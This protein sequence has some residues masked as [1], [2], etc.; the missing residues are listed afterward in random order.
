MISL[1]GVNGRSVINSKVKTIARELSQRAVTIMKKPQFLTRWFDKPIDQLKEPWYR[2]GRV[3]SIIDGVVNVK[4]GTTWLDVGC[5]IGQFLHVVNVNYSISGSGIDDFDD[6]NVIEICRKYFQ[7]EIEHPKDL[8]A[9]YS[10]KY[11]PRRIDQI[12]FALNER[13]SFI[14][15]LEVLEHMINTDAF[16]DECNEHLETRGYLVISTPNINSL[17]NRFTGWWGVYPTGLEY[18]TVVH[19]V[20]LYNAK[21]L[22]QHVESRGFELVTLA[23]V[24]FL[25]V[26]LLTNDAV[27]FLDPILSKLFPSLC[28]NLVAVFRK[29]T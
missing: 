28:G 15:A 4:A 5:Q 1:R 8:F 2:F 23:G 10:W 3:I 16:I 29:L 17:R 25:P 19:H 21:V 14:S 20:R 26:R 7:L 6:S 27:R 18:R 22:V 12:G 11:Y 9:N 24:S 13:F